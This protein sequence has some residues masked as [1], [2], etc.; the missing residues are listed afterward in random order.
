M[1]FYLHDSSRIVHGLDQR[2][3]KFLS[4]LSPNA[5]SIFRVK[6][7]DEDIPSFFIHFPDDK[8]LSEDSSP[9]S[10]SSVHEVPVLVSRLL[11][12]FSKQSSLM[13][14]LM[15]M[16]YDKSEC[17]LGSTEE[18]HTPDSANCTAAGQSPQSEIVSFEFL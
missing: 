13:E 18:L 3:S 9:T 10:D 15:D 6:D 17:G 11:Q 14:N 16:F 8:A 1:N 5:L 2:K 4:L 12:L 7:H